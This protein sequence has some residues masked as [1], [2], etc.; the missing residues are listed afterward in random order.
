MTDEN[1]IKLYFDR[2]EQAISATKS[3]YGKYLYTIAYNI[4]HINE[5]CEES[6]SETYLGAWNT[7]P[8]KKPN[9]LQTYL[10]KL[11]RNIS[12]KRFRNNSAQKRGGTQTDIAL[13]ELSEVLASNDSVEETIERDVLLSF[14]QQF[15]E[16]LENEQRR[17][18]IARYWYMYSIKDISQKLGYSESKVKSTLKRTRDKLKD[19]IEKEGLI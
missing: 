1:I 17:I 8:P 10:G 6:V 7:M 11:T 19:E 4:L 9:V 2:N 16:G 14:I 5:D 18:F 12:L 3:K 15:I 13:E